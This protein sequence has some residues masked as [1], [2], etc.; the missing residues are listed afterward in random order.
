MDL[1]WQRHYNF[2]C[3]NNR[4]V[5]IIRSIANFFELYQ[6]LADSWMLFNNAGVIPV[7]IAEGKHGKV[8]IANESSYNTIV[9]GIRGL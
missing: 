3:M 4:N 2:G 1:R 6:P 8:K 7:L 5:Y 9:Q